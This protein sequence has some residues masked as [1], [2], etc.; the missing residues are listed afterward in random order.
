MKQ[1]TINHLLKWLVKFDHGCDD[2]TIETILTNN[3][4]G[5][6]SKDKSYL[7]HNDIYIL[8]VLE[9]GLEDEMLAFTN[10]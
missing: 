2:V 10:S 4:S 5:L 3:Y 7:D 1:K 6:R 8:S 9:D